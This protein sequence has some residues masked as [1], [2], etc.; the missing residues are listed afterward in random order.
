MRGAG[1]ETPCPLQYVAGL[2]GNCI[3]A[4]HLCRILNSIVLYGG[5]TNAAERGT[6]AAERNFLFHFFHLSKRKY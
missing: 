2:S 5:I 6:N 4:L 3:A 1:L